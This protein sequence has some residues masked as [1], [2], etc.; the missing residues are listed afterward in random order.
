VEPSTSGREGAC[1]LR[2]THKGWAAAPDVR[3][4]R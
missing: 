4:S 2:M 3:I 1:A